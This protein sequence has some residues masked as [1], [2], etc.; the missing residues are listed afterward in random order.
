MNP[1]RRPFRDVIERQL[2]LFERENADLLEEIA[3]AER[4]YDRSER[5]DAEERYGDFLDL[6]ESAGEAL[7][8]LRDGFATTLSGEAEDA[9]LDAFNRA[10]LRRWPRLA[11][12]L[13]Q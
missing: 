13:D 10:A 2:V 12:G 7:A 1:F 5:D 9:Y 11:T 3:A 8:E 4:A 6:V